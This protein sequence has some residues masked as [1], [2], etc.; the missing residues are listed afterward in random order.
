[1]N[2]FIPM[3]ILTLAVVSC[4]SY[5]FAEEEYDLSDHPVYNWEYNPDA[6][7]SSERISKPAVSN[8]YSLD[9]LKLDDYDPTVVA[10]QFGVMEFD[11]CDLESF[12]KYPKCK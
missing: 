4:T 9:I 11:Y 1:M 3:A 8:Q 7:I 10:Y 2:K 5:V 6:N 12:A